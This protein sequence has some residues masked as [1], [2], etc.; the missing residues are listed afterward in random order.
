MAFLALLYF[1]LIWFGSR[2]YNIISK[3]NSDRNK[4]K[5]DIMIIQQ[6]MGIEFKVFLFSDHSIKLIRLTNKRAT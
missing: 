6:S 4:I 2:P 5:I 3:R 1:Y